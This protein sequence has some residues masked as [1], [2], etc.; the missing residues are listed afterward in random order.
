M[1]K[2]IL[3]V[4]KNEESDK[5]LID[6]TKRLSKSFQSKITLM[7]LPADDKEITTKMGP[8]ADKLKKELEHENIETAEPILTNQETTSGIIR[9]IQ[10]KN[11]G[12]VLLTSDDYTGEEKDTKKANIKLIQKTEIPILG[13]KPGSS[14]EM[15][16]ILCPVDLSKNSEKA[17]KNAISWAKIFDSQLLVLSVFEPLTSTSVFI[18]EGNEDLFNE[19]KQ[20]LDSFLKKTDFNDVN[21]N[22]E[23]RSGKPHEEITAAVHEYGADLMIMGST[24][25]SGIPK[26]IM[27]S[28]AEKMI[29]TMPCSLVVLRDQDVISSDS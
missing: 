8:Y 29:N 22:S 25:R 9:V 28:V 15:K 5:S 12:L 13:V 7:Y 18:N 14:A 4:L 24:G 23:I 3:V 19:H 11:T 1:P 2:N 6:I 26:K 17:L 20:F 27:G 16:K 10:E 21:W